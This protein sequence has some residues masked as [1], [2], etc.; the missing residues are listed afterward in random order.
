M[1]IEPRSP[2]TS[3]AQAQFAPD[4]TMVA[5]SAGFL[6]DD[7]PEGFLA[8]CDRID[9]AP[10]VKIEIFREAGANIVDLA[11]RV[12]ERLYGTRAVHDVAVS[13]GAARTGRQRRERG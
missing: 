8:A 3:P 5:S 10:A 11:R 13:L 9:G 6:D 1:N 12:R 2:E 4:G 7:G